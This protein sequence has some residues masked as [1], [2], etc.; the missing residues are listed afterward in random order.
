MWLKLF[1]SGS[2]R[3]SLAGLPGRGVNHNNCY[4]SDH[5]SVQRKE[6]ES[7]RRLSEIVGDCVGAVSPTHSL[8][9]WWQLLDRPHLLLLGMSI[10]SRYM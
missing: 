7:L 4:I 2:R 8:V 5:T 6:N 3:S 9:W 10:L 1:Q